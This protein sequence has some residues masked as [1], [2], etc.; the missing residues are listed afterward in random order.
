MEKINFKDIDFSTFQKSSIQGTK[1]TIYKNKEVAIKILDKFYPEEK[2]ELYRKLLDMDGITIDK[3]LLP[4]DIILKDH[5]LYGYTMDYFQDSIPLLDYFGSTRYVNCNDI[6]EAIKKSSLI[7]R[8][9][10]QNGIICGDLSFDNILINREQEIKYCD[11]DGCFY[12]HH[13]GPFI[14]ILL[15]TFLIDYRHEK[16][17]ISENIDQISMML[18]F[19]LLLYSKELQELS[20]REYNQLL[21]HIT[22]LQNMDGYAKRLIDRTKKIP[23]IPYLDELIDEFDDYLIDREKQLT[24][25]QKILRRCGK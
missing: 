6:F 12:R 14:S 25:K 2:E 22:T 3:V 13:Q 15:K 18:S 16:V 17:E 8:D 23:E 11:M 7:L 4:K 9:I 24:I 20:K 10:H 21:K 5:K 19:Y 1:S